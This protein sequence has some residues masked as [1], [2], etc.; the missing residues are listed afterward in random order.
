MCELEGVDWYDNGFS[1]LISKAGFSQN[2]IRSNNRYFLEGKSDL[3]VAVM[4]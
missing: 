4:R 1:L 3:G 2:F